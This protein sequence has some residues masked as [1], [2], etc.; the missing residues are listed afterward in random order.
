MPLGGGRLV[1][2]QI[3]RLKAAP[4]ETPAR[5]RMYARMVARRDPGLP[6]DAESASHLFDSFYASLTAR[7]WGWR[8]APRSS[9]RKAGHALLSLKPREPPFSS[10]L[11]DVLHDLHIHLRSLRYRG[12]S[13]DSRERRSRQF[14]GDAKRPSAGPDNRGRR[15]GYPVQAAFR[16]RRAITDQS[17]VGGTGQ[18]RFYMAWNSIWAEPI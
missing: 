9:L 4:Y 6:V 3:P 5:G 17:R 8:L 2:G 18:S 11:G 16:K 1:R 12:N 14:A 7:A 15:T 13:R 10:T